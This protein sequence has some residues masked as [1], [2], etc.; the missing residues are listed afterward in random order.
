MKA[1]LM[2]RDRDFDLQE[3]PSHR[4]RREAQVVPKVVPNED[5]LTQDLEL[6][7]LFNAMAG[8]DTLLFQVA[9]Q[10]VLSGLHNDRETILY[11]QAIL[12]DC[13]KN[14]SVVR[15]IYAAAVETIE[16]EKRRWYGVFSRR[17]PGS[18]LGSGVDL[19]QLYMETLGK[20][21]LLADEHA[22]QFASEGFR[23][24]FALLEAEL[25]DEYFVA[26]EAHLK[27][28]KFRGGVLESAELGKGNQGA[29]YVLRK[30]LA[31]KP[32]WLRRLLTRQPPAYTFRL[33]ERDEAGARALGELRDRGINLVANALA[34]SADHVLAF[35]VTLRRELA[36]YLGCVNLHR[37]LGRKGAPVCFPEPTLAGEP[38]HSCVG[39]RDACL[40]LSMDRTVVGNDLNAAGKRLVIITGANQGGKSTF[41][42]SLG[43]A[44]L[45]MQCG[46]FVA[47]ESFSA[48]ICHGLFT[49]YKR[50]EDASMK[51]GKLDE[52][53]SR[54]SG[55]VDALTPNSVLLFNE[56]FAA[57]NEREGSEIARQIV[58]ALLET[59]V[60]VFFVTHLY[61]FAHGL[62][63]D[64]MDSAIFLRAERQADGRRTFKLVP[65]EPFQTS[66]GADLYEEIR[67]ATANCV[68]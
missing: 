66:Y 57:T 67:S 21:K 6:N 46:M 40:A 42:R 31:K 55:I 35:F 30:S 50:E 54:M 37:H 3:P 33:H 59:R 20:L 62:C 2:F 24:F 5:A 28:L 9:R 19:V 41:L 16:S 32:G 47:A 45:M 38:R 61:K 11:R 10:A 8:G 22:G 18:I 68:A 39:L 36:F 64:K 12:Q 14:Y 34:Q 49:H 48:D 25:P 60:K 65:G 56:S 52:E 15:N 44:Q 23:A 26:V 17:Y 1:R 4:Y 43:L 63:E 13:L 29:N 27:E 53:L 7:T 58:R 51:S